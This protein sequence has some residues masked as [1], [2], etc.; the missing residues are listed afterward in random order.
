M[1]GDP[2]QRPEWCMSAA[3]QKRCHRGCGGLQGLLVADPDLIDQARALRRP[4]P[5]AIHRPTFRTRWRASLPQGHYERTICGATTVT[6][7]SAGNAC[8]PLTALSAVDV[9]ALWRGANMLTPSGCRP[10]R[11][12]QRQQL[13]ARRPAGV[14]IEPGARHFLNAA[15]PDSLFSHGVPR[16]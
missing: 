3:C 5:I 6:P 14:L 7:P 8:M 10:R 4:G 2:A 1:A 13:T 15:P 9:P 16:H 11:P 12:D